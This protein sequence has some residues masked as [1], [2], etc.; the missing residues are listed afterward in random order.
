MHT[1]WP[2]CI[3]EVVCEQHRYRPWQRAQR[4]ALCALLHPDLCQHAVCPL[5]M[6]ILRGCAVVGSCTPCNLSGKCPK[7]FP[8]LP[9]HA[10]VTQPL[11]H[12]S[13]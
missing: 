9:L 2:D 12:T 6:T 1:S 3:G 10:S 8:L 5:C 11:Q 4:Q 13:W 7:C